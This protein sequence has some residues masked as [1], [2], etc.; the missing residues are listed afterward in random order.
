MGIRRRL[1]SIL[2]LFRLRGSIRRCSRM[3]VATECLVLEPR[4]LLVANI[5]LL[6]ID[7]QNGG[8]QRVTSFGPGES[9]RVIA[10]WQTTDLPTGVKYDL[11]FT[12]DGV[13]LIAPNIDNR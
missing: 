12:V 6:G 4:A 13:S 7:L 9:I 3:G 10:K 5:R 8:G 11:I 1:N 2:R